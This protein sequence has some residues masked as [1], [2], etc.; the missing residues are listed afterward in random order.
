[1]PSALRRRVTSRAA[2]R[3]EYCLVRSEDVYFKHQ[4]DHVISEKHGGRTMSGNLALACVHCNLHKGSD[5]G[6]VVPGANRFCRL[7]NPRTD[8]WSDHFA[9]VGIEILPR[10]KVGEAT[11]RILQLNSDNQLARRHAL[12]A[13]GAYPQPGA[14]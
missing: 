4:V 9:L 8:L 6:S 7:F 11:I 10:S 3:C 14:G 12:V 5:V 13:A 1:M 2:G